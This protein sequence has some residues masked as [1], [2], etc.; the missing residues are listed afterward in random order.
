MELIWNREHLEASAAFYK[1]RRN[2]RYKFHRDESYVVSRVFKFPIT[3][4]SFF[5]VPNLP[6]DKV[7]V[8]E[9]RELTDVTSFSC[10]LFKHYNYKSRKK[11]RRE[12]SE[13]RRNKKTRRQKIASETTDG[14]RF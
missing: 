12:S 5:S 4:N 9:K 6:L 3:M 11:P 10:Y 14:Q 8:G 1:F 13:R 2:N 7:D